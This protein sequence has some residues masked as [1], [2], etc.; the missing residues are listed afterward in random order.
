MAED[1]E[2][3]PEEIFVV[4]KVSEGVQIEENQLPIDIAYSKFI[5]AECSLH[6]GIYMSHSCALPERFT[7][8]ALSLPHQATVPTVPPRS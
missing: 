4:E 2:D 5:G 3:N 8:E 1:Q 6:C 7:V